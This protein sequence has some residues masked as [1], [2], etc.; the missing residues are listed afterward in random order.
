MPVITNTVLLYV[1]DELKN[2]DCG[3]LGCDTVWSCRWLPMFQR[4]FCSHLQDHMASQSTSLLLL[5]P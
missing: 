1:K 5:E 3:H 2:I 4:N